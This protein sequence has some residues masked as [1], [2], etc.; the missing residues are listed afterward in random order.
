M[1]PRLPAQVALVAGK[2]LRIE[3][4]SRVTT[5]QVLPFAGVVLLLFAFAL[6]P[7]RGLLPR[8]A[9]GLF[10]VAVLLAALLAVGRAFAVEAENGAREGLRLSALDP[11]AMFL[12][13][14]AAVAVQLVVLEAVLALTMFVLY[15]VEV[16][17][18]ALLALS[19]VLA[20]AG[21]AAAGSVYGVLAAGLRVRET[22]LPLLLLPVVAPVMLAATR[23]WEAGLAGTPGEAW[24]WVQ[25]MGA[26]L[27]IYT[28]LGVL[29]FGP[30]LEEV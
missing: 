7:D 13:K 14:A 16:R 3:A 10:W 26:F 29:A 18:P 23:A 27:A 2:D 25:V 19:A 28:V 30:L 24:P 8:V 6:D 15:D 21:V 12:G 17:S 4:R 11:A 1:S 9:P 22:L 20:T 5:N